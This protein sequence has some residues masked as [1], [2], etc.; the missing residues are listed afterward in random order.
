MQISTN[1]DVLAQ[2]RTEWTRL[3]RSAASRRALDSLLAAAPEEVPSGIRDL[4]DLVLALEPMG[5]LSQLQRAR[6]LEVLL[7]HA[8]DPMVRRC[9]LQTLIPG[10]V[11][12]AR[13][14]RFGEGIADDPGT[15]LADGLAEASELLCD[16]AGQRRPYAGP[17]LLGALRCRMRRRMLSDKQR[18][19]ELTGLPDRLGP[20]RV[21]HLAELAATL[22]EAA[23]AGIPDTELVYARCILGVPASE[24]ADALGISGGA[25]KRRLAAVATPLLS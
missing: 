15:F 9:L 23:A 10:I 22:R 4:G 11:S 24:L 2:L 14:L 17:D 7:E 18:R 12:V 13:K 1:S 3:G 25:V 5:G 16:W 6:I 19:S 8:G 21:D 20:Q